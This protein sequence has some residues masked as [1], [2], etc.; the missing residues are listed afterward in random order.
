VRARGGRIGAH[1]FQA[2]QDI[3]AGQ[4][5]GRDAALQFSGDLQ[6]KHGDEGVCAGPVGLAE[7]DRAKL[8]K[9]GLHGAEVAFDVL[10]VTVAVPDGLGGRILDGHVRHD[11]IAPI[12]L[13][14]LRASGLVDDEVDGPLVE[15]RGDVALELV[16]LQPLVGLAEGDLGV[17]LLAVGHQLVARVDLGLHTRPAQMFRTGSSVS[18]MLTRRGLG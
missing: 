4:P 7:E 1:S 17:C 10:E 3:L 15:D 8:K 13:L 12:E 14:E 9:G 16:G 2:L 11:D 5:Q 6:G 18:P